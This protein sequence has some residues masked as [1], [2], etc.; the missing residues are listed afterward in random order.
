LNPVIGI[1][2]TLKDLEERAARLSD[3]VA[4][5][6]SVDDVPEPTSVTY[7]D[8]ENPFVSVIHTLVLKDCWFMG[9][10]ESLSFMKLQVH[11]ILPR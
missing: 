6:F 9:H 5:G 8:H 10:P 3:E 4:P 11:R 7:I 2:E 1:D